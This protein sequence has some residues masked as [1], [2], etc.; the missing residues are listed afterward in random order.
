MSR[1]VAG[2]HEAAAAPAAKDSEVSQEKR[3][4]AHYVYSPVGSDTAVIHRAEPATATDSN[5]P[6]YSALYLVGSWKPLLFLTRQTNVDIDIV[7]SAFM[8]PRLRNNGV[9]S[10]RYLVVLFDVYLVYHFY[11]CRGDS[12]ACSTRRQM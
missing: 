5:M 9:R 2:E 6:H 1:R 7:C 12:S 4:V 10:R 11:F 8:S 3:A